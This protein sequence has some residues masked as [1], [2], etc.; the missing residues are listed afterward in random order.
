MTEHERLQ[1]GKLAQDILNNEVF[2]QTVEA[3][4]TAMIAEFLKANPEEAIP[5]G[6]DCRRFDRFAMRLTQTLR[7][8]ASDIRMI[9]EFGQKK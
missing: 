5:L 9:E 3:I 4:R 7:D 6:E 2:N 1:R 8:Y